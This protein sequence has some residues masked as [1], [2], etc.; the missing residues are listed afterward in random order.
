MIAVPMIYIDPE[1]YAL[2]TEHAEYMTRA[3]LG[4]WTPEESLVVGAETWLRGILKTK[5][6][7]RRE[8]NVGKRKNPRNHR[9]PRQMA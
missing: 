6:F 1:L 4:E 7:E 3:G 8:T 5:Y 2:M 9:K